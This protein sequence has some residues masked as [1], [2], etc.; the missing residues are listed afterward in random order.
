M[1]E[2]TIN[3]K[4]LINQYTPIDTPYIQVELGG[5]TLGV[6]VNDETSDSFDITKYL[7]R[8]V[9]KYP[10]LITGVT[11][12]RLAN[13]GIN[14]YEIKLSYAPRQGDDP[15]YVDKLLSYSSFN[16]ATDLS[17]DEKYQVLLTGYINQ[18]GKKYTPEEGSSIEQRVADLQLLVSNYESL[19]NIRKYS[20]ISSQRSILIS[21]GNSDPNSGNIYRTDEALVISYTPDIRIDNGTIDYTIKAVSKSAMSQYD[22][23]PFGNT[24]KSGTKLSKEIART[25]YDKTYGLEAIFP[26]GLYINGIK[27]TSAT[28][29]A[30]DSPIE[31][32]YTA[33]VDMTPLDY[34]KSL[35]SMMVYEKIGE[36]TVEN[37]R[38]MVYTDDSYD[39]KT[40]RS[41][42]S[43]RITRYNTEIASYY[44][45]LVEI[46]TRDSSVISFS[47]NVEGQYSLAIAYN[48]SVKYNNSVKYI[49]NDNA[50]IKAV[51]S[52]SPVLNGSDVDTTGAESYWWSMMSS[53]PII[54]TITIRGLAG[55]LNIMDKIRLE[56]FQYGEMYWLSGRYAVIGITDSVN[57]QG[58]QSTL[59][60][61][62]ISDISGKEFEYRES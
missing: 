19:Y 28:Y 37:S 60:L 52:E 26:G 12:K 59:N 47:A 43:L 15:N 21:Y 55:R 3:K 35:V 27:V 31:G 61:L 44:R 39:I 14:E 24:L 38:Y 23:Y 46:G 53:Y 62:R 8:D 11:A 36:S 30:D 7:M 56:I 57:D 54:T 13:D 4:N 40:H 49:I 48:K 51:N 45:Y 2:Y 5:A 25:F 6:Y 16:K 29:E 42:A 9:L 10:N 41:N 50:E 17:I 32:N 58:Y 20:K 33:G 22:T 34:I 1:N 18:L